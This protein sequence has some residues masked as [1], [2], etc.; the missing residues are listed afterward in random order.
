MRET[1][2]I[3][4][5]F[6]KMKQTDTSLLWF[7]INVSIFSHISACIWYFIAKIN[8]FD[9]NTWVYKQGVGDD[10][11][12]TYIYA[13]YWSLQTLTTVGFGDIIPTNDGKNIY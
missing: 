3:K 1:Q 11:L 2:G 13:L 7:L 4:D 9:T 5:V 8:Y 6:R 12:K 10:I